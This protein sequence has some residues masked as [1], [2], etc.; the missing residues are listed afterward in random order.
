MGNLMGGEK[1]PA[2]AVPAP[3][4][5]KPTISEKDKAMLK[6][7]GQKDKLKQFERRAT[8][9]ADSQKKV[10]QQLAKAGK[11]NQAMLVLKQKKLI[12][13]QVRQNH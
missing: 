11:R 1:E 6:L 7:K 4:A 3:A 13:Q 10:A 5:A 9:K 8:A 2:A 12:E